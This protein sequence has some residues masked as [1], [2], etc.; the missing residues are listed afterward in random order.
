M[1]DMKRLFSMN[2][3]RL[4]AARNMNQNDLAKALGFNR[5]TVNTWCTGSAF[6]TTD[7]IQMIADYF[8]V[9]KSELIEPYVP[10]SVN[11]SQLKRLMVYFYALN[12]MGIEEALKRVEE[13]TEIPKYQKD[14]KRED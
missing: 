3:K 2:L 8:G 12:G 9:G 6:P 14:D 13:L 4:M 11:Q 7:K 1:D 10:Q 5:T